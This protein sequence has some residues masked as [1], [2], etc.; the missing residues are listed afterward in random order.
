[1]SAVPT[2]RKTPLNGKAAQVDTASDGAVSKSSVPELAH[3]YHFL[4]P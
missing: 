3:G 4:G 2:N 1:M